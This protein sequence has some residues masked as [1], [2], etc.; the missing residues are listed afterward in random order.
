MAL[1]DS[2]FVF[3]AW[4][5]TF[6]A[7]TIPAV[8]QAPTFANG[9]ST[10]ARSWLHVVAV[11][12]L[13]GDRLDDVV[14]SQVDALY[15]LRILLS[16]GDGTFVVTP[17]VQG[18]GMRH[19][20]RNGQLTDL[21][22]DGWLDLVGF[23]S[24]HVPGAQRDLILINDRGVSLTTLQDQ[25]PETQ[26]H[27]GGAV[28][29][30]NRDGLPDI[31][32]IREFGYRDY[33]GTDPR[34]PLL[35]QSDGTFAPGPGVLPSVLERYA[36]PSAA[37]ADLDGDGADD[38]VLALATMAA[39][40]SGD[41]LSE[42]LIEM[43]PA[44]AIAINQPG[45]PIGEWPFRLLGRHWID[46]SGYRDFASRFGNP[47]GQATAG[48][49]SLALLD[50]NDDG[51]L[52]IVAGSFITEAFLQR[53]GGFQVFINQRGEFQER[54]IDFF[55]NQLANRDF[56]V[57]FNFLYHLVDLNSDG[58]K[59]LVVTTS[60]Q[61][62]WPEHSE[63]GAYP[64]IFI[65][66]PDGMF[67]PAD[68]DNMRVFDD[69]VIGAYGLGN[70]I[71]G[72]FNGDGVPDL[73]SLRRESDFDWNLPE[74]ASRSGEV[75][76]THIN[77]AIH[78]HPRSAMTLLGTAGDDVLQTMDST[79]CLRGLAGDDTLVGSDRLIDVAVY[80]GRRGDFDLLV[81]GAGAR[82][83]DRFG[84][85]GADRL[86]GVERLLFSD[87]AVALDHDGNAGFAV[88]LL[89]ALFGKESVSSR[90]HVGI[91]VGLL[92]AGMGRTALGN[93]GLEVAGLGTA[94][95]IVAG[96][97]KNLI[98]TFPTEFE[99]RPFVDLLDNGMEPGEL[100]RLAAETPLA[101]SLVDLVGL[102]STG[103]EYFPTA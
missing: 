1:I 29:D 56:D 13:N 26:G 24:S 99:K 11:G 34:R 17:M 14:L 76:V 55:P 44:L 52:D 103:I 83:V 59:D 47:T 28:G 75:V 8:Y 93:L 91:A 50:I 60:H 37:M 57:S 16:R 89:A 43:T 62:N 39:D 72:D 61:V 30:I 100:A 36:I 88:R 81:E 6:R 95:Q 45:I 35:Q 78:K 64:S 58:R 2:S 51:W 23:E 33:R 31:F 19:F 80:H 65:R 21:N 25:L 38:L 53:G 97:W 79:P 48:T 86:I 85:E 69:S 3:E 84:N 63:F 92:D 41:Q 15:D 101:A 73:M 27:H 49:N 90:S 98:G 54:T 68:V 12:D 40:L 82:V 9:F 77:Q 74:S 18:D 46:D 4:F 96:I 10:T 5:E 22:H 70:L 20:I 42:D 7:V 71:A 102:A 66:Q 94:D 87:V 32:G 67:L